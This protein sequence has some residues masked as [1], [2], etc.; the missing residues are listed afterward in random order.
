MTDPVPPKPPKPKKELKPL[1][2]D[3][4]LVVM[5]LLLAQSVGR[6]PAKLVILLM[7]ALVAAVVTGVSLKWSRPE[8]DG[9]K[10]LP[11]RLAPDTAAPALTEQDLQGTW[12]ANTDTM[13]MSLLVEKGGYEWVAKNKEDKYLR[14]YAVGN[15]RI[16][17]NVLVLGQR[18][19]LAPPEIAGDHFIQFLPLGFA[20]IN[21]GAQVN[22]RLML[23]TLPATERRRLDIDFNRIFPADPARPITWVRSRS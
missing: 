5:K 22:D 10:Y 3:H 19:D 21:F 20:N 6:M 8:S 12:I 16:E 4:P 18:S 17:G 11:L 7:A 14:L 1:P 15:Y 2:P 13:V 23:W 9:N